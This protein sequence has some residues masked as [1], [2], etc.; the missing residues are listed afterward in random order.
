M[1]VTKDVT[2]IE[3]LYN[4][5]PEISFNEVSGRIRDDEENKNVD[6]SD[7]E[8]TKYSTTSAVDLWRS[9]R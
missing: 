7:M 2:F 5:D 6:V 4:I 9:R 8:Y 3:K 1:F